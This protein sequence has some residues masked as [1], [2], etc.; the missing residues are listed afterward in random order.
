MNN[1]KSN[2]NGLTRGI[3][4]NVNSNIEKERKETISKEPNSGD[5]GP[6]A[7]PQ[8][9]EKG[10]ILSMKQKGSDKK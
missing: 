2:N 5:K 3:R 4:N 6:P 9:P 8:S 1:P 10:R 7:K